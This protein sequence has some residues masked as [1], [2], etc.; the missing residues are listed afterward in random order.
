MKVIFSHKVALPSLLC[1]AYVVISSSF[2]FKPFTGQ[3]DSLL[4]LPQFYEGPRL[5][6][7]KLLVREVH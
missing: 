3:L 1:G 2:S 6:S 7:R 5:E 4:F